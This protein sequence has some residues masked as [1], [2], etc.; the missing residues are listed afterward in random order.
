MRAAFQLIRPRALQRELRAAAVRSNTGRGSECMST[1]KGWGRA[2]TQNQAS[3]PE[4]GAGY[5]FLFFCEEGGGRFSVAGTQNIHI[6][7][8][9]NFNLE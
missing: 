4:R 8:K 6:S 3:L 9:M 2:P 1:E 5:V 7:M